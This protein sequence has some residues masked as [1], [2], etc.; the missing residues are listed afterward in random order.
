LVS[1]ELSAN[2]RWVTFS[3]DKT[4]AP[5]GALLSAG[6]NIVRQGDPE[7]ELGVSIGRYNHSRGTEIV[8]RTTRQ[9]PSPQHH[10]T[11]SSYYGDEQ[12]S[13]EEEILVE[14]EPVKYQLTN[15]AFQ[16]PKTSAGHMPTVEES[17]LLA[18]DVLENPTSDQAL[19]LSVEIPYKYAESMKIVDVIGT[20]PGIST[21]FDIRSPLTLNGGLRVYLRDFGFFG[22]G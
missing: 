19:S 13:P 3:K 10:H 14:L 12:S 16:T 5:N 7:S 4:R 15:L 9:Q 8:L 2:T 21:V 11:S 6:F 20:K 22:K 18:H 1:P 17:V